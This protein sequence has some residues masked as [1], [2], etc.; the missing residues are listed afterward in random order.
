VS[1]HFAFEREL[2]VV[3]LA[4]GER[5]QICQQVFAEQGEIHRGLKLI[6]VDGEV[7]PLHWGRD[8]LIR[9]GRADVI[10]R[11]QIP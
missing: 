6:R 2:D 1:E 11:H 10:D 7:V 8:L 5:V 9:A 3:I 4:T